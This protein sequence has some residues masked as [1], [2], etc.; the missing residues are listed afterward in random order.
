MDHK[1]AVQFPGTD[2]PSVSH[3]TLQVIVHNS[4]NY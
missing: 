1:F 2:N 4:N 3:C